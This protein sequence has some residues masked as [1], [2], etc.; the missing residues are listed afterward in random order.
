MNPRRC[1]VKRKRRLAVLAMLLLSIAVPALA[2]ETTGSITGI[3]VDAQG[4]PIPGATV[5]ITG[6]QGA[7]T[8][9]SESTGRFNVPFL[10]PGM[11]SVRSE[12][13]GFKP[14]ER[15]N[16]NVGLAQTVDLSLKMDVGGLTETVQVS[17]A[18]PVIDTSTTTIGAN[19]DSELLSRLPVGRRFS[20]TLYIAPGVS[21]GGTVGQANPSISGGSGLENQYVVDGV[22][23][24]NQGYG[25][26]GSYS[27][28]FGSLGNGTPFDFMKEVQVKS[29]GFEAEY[30]QA[31]GGVV[32][33]VTKSG[34]NN[35]R[36]TV[37]GYTRPDALESDY[38]QVDTPNGTVN[39]T[40]SQLSDVGIE[41]GGPV[42]KDKL[43]FF[44]AID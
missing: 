15:Q 44:G 18:S 10:I 40:G 13:Q 32:N 12:L 17:S 26:L 37:F 21:T 8:A 34:S 38:D 29:G 25:A 42:L 36:G 24:T 19:I 27:I 1:V 5:T 16:V 28:V 11:Y 4:L 3:I 22:N 2:Q 7:K 23:I 30:G 31:T 39:T 14:I 33:V 35:L 43:F 6:P 41:A 20:D 9:V